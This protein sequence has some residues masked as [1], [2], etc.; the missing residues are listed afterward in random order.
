MKKVIFAI[1]VLSL[2]TFPAQSQKIQDQNHKEEIEMKVKALGY[3]FY[4]NGERLT[5]KELIEETQSVEK[6]NELIKRA[7][8]QRTIS[9]ILGFTG[10]A[11]IGIP[12][13]QK[14]A[15]R[16]PSWEFAY[17]GGAVVLVGLHLS[18]RVFNNV[19]KGVDTY[20]IAVA[21]K[22]SYRFQPEFFVMN[23]QNGFG[24]TMRF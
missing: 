11:L 22:S 6:A 24:M 16:E 8:S 7:R 10:G 20:N 19:N 17:V 12:L 4:K 13:G 9:S 5:W 21:P 1:L 2:G 23:N 14:S 3:R 15:D 18:F